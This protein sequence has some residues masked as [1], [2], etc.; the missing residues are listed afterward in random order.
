MIG[1]FV[2]SVGVEIECGI[3][4]ANLRKW[5]AWVQ[6]NSQ[7]NKAAAHYVMTG[8]TSFGDY[9]WSADGILARE[10]TFWSDDIDD[11]KKAITYLFSECNVK[12]T[13]KCGG[14]I[15]FR[16]KLPDTAESEY[17]L[18]SFYSSSRVYKALISEMKKHFMEKGSKYSNRLKNSYCKPDSWGRRDIINKIHGGGSRY[19]FINFLSLWDSQRTIEVRGFPA[20]DT[21]SEEIENVEYLIKL[22]NSVTEKFCNRKPLFTAEVLKI[23]PTE[24]ADEGMTFE[25]KVKDIE[26]KINGV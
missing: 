4:P 1:K 13:Y 15:H 26:N 8:D 7:T 24:I 10:I 17:Q 18:M 11:L 12:T 21:A 23:V 3:T 14:H 6:R 2:S 25:E 5:D 20:A 19:S 22:V 16:A 9:S